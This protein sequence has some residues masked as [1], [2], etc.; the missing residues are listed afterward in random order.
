[1]TESATPDD[2]DVRSLAL[3]GEI[4]IANADDV[5]AAALDAL[6]AGPEI[7][8]LALAGITFIDSSGLC[9]LVR[10]RNEAASRDVGLLLVRVP[11][12]IARVMEVSGLDE[13]FDVRA[14]D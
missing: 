3:S 10:I 13:A 1:M 7:L 8:E 14:G 4:D 2:V 11:P 6:D 5:V 12:A 9:A